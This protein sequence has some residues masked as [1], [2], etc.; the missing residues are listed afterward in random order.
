MWFGT[1]TLNG[2]NYAYILLIDNTSS[3]TDGGLY[4]FPTGNTTVQMTLQLGSSS[5]AI[6]T[7]LSVLFAPSH[8]SVANIGDAYQETYSSQLGT[9]FVNLQDDIWNEGHFM[10]GD[11]NNTISTLGENF[12]TMSYALG[13]LSYVLSVTPPTVNYD[14]MTI[15]HLYSAAFTWMSALCIAGIVAIALGG[16]GLIVATVTFSDG[17]G[18]TVSGLMFSWV[19]YA[20]TG[21]LLY[22]QC[23]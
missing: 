16:Y 2:Y 6:V 4:N 13:D 14:S 11:L 23:G 8:G 9:A 21:Y 10:I 12:M 20:M 18:L 1:G 19:S 17:T 22:L 5:S 3:H 15:P 7:A